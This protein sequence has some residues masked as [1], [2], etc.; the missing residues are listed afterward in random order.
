MEI[1]IDLLHTFYSVMYC[2]I[3]DRWV[4]KEMG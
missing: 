4:G 2:S 3:Y 1:S